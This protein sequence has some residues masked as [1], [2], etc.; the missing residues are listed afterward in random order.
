MFRMRSP[1]RQP[2]VVR[3]PVAPAVEKP[4][5]QHHASPMGNRD[6]VPVFAATWLAGV[7]RV[8]CAFV[9]GE[10]FGAELTLV[11]ATVA[12][13]PVLLYGARRRPAS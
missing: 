9:H 1:Y 5:A 13:V 7:A 8:L 10:T 11:L 3:A 12:M 6:I 2:A 4:V